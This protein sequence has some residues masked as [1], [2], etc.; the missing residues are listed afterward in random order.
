LL[1]VIGIIALLISILLPVMGKARA[2]AQSLK[3]MSNLRTLG[4]ATGMYLISYR[5]S[6]PYPTTLYP[7]ASQQAQEAILWFNAVDPFLQKVQDSQSTT[8]RFYKN[9]KQCVVYENFDGRE[10][11]ANG[12]QGKLK[13][14]SRSYKMN[15]HL[16]A[17]GST[18]KITDVK[19]SARVVYLGDGLSLDQIGPVP[20]AFEN[21]QFS[22]EV[23]DTQDA[24]PQA[25][26]ALR[27]PG[28]SSNIL[29]IDG[30]VE[31]VKL[32]TIDRKLASP[33]QAV[34]LK[35]WES[36][37]ISG[38]NSQYNPTADQMSRYSMDTL[39][40]RRNPDMPLIW[41]EW[42]KYYRFNN[43]NEQ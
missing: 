19:Q 17:G 43:I 13:G 11:E 35:T 2:S 14:F 9:Y 10:I 29:F 7:G 16:R 42:G 24:D 22:M 41:S 23:N 3:C 5:N 40:V 36:E 6:L 26:P 34:R 8:G 39:K 25:T 37:Y 4:Q 21:G 18:L 28:G 12:N 32:P 15:T 20:D 1:V 33:L 27:H 31:N 30:H 38:A